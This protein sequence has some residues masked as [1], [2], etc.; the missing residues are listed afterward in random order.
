MAEL[1]K[2][3]SKQEQMCAYVRA[4]RFYAQ[5]IHNLQKQALLAFFGGL[6]TVRRKRAYFG[7][8]GAILGLPLAARVPIGQL[9]YQKWE[10]PTE[11]ETYLAQFRWEIGTVCGGLNWYW[12]G[13][14][15]W[16]GA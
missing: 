6:F 8:L 3:G 4:Q 12:M 9:W 10:S 13:G 14:T 2:S 15:G 7:P 5:S 16:G 1:V 11:N